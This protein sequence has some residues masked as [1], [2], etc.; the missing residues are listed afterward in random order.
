MVEKIDESRL[1]H[2]DPDPAPVTD[3]ARSWA[4]AP[5]GSRNGEPLNAEPGAIPEGSHVRLLSDGRHT[6]SGVI[7]V[8]MPDGSAFW[9]WLDD[10]AGRRL[11]HES[12]AVQITVSP[13][14]PG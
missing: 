4:C 13:A 5:E 1:P 9:I 3:A 11:V 2:E 7:D 8:W 6:M 14:G 10:G 12:D